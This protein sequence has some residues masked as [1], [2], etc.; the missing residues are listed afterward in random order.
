MDLDQKLGHNVTFAAFESLCVVLHLARTFQ[1]PRWD[2]SIIWAMN[3]K[4][5]LVRQYV[6]GTVVYHLNSTE[7]SK[8]APLCQ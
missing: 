6:E 1:N 7:R 8:R 4:E 5:H 2:G 3:K